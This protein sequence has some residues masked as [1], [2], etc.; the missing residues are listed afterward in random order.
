MIPKRK[1]DCLQALLHVFRNRSEVA[2]F[3]TGLNVNPAGLALTFD[4]IRRRKKLDV[5]HLVQVDPLTGGRVDQHL[6]DRVDAVA[7]LRRGPNL[8]VVGPTAREDVADFLAR[9]QD[10]RCTPQISRLQPIA[11]RFGKSLRNLDVRYIHI[12]VL[13]DFVGPLDG[14]KRLAHELRLLAQH[15]EIGTENAHHNRLAFP[16][17][18]LFDALIQIRLHTAK[19]TRI[20]VHHLLDSG[21]RLLVIDVR[22]DADPVLTVGDADDFICQKRLTYM[23]A[24]IANA[25]DGTQLM[26]YPFG[27]AEHFRI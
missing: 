9:Y 19:Q 14:C 26:A 18:N 23:S 16:R 20:A 22:V 6:C 8:D 25:W 24:E 17:Q 12:D 1:L 10:G 27:G 3:D 13:F 21:N 4:D 7:P 11:Q 15:G 5:C 2:S